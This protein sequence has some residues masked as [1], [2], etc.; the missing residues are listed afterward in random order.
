MGT[1]ITTGRKVKAHFRLVSAGFGNAMREYFSIRTRAAMRIIGMFMEV[2][3]WGVLGML[4]SGNV[5]LEE[6]IRS[7]YMTPDMVSFMLSGLIINRMVDMAQIFNP[8]FFR[9]GYKTYHNRPF[10][11]WV[12][13]LAK[14]LDSMFFWRFMGLIMYILVAA[15][16]FRVNLNYTSVGFWFVILL[17]ALFRLGLN[18]FTA[19]WTVLTKGEQDPI[20]WFYN[21]T[22]RLFTG[23]LIP[24]TYIK[25]IPL[26]GPY[27]HYVSLVHPKTYVQTEGRRAAIGGAGLG[28]VAPNL[29]VPL[30]AAIFFLV[31]GYITLRVAIKRAKR[32]GIMKWG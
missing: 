30:I 2:A 7:F 27:L 6:S 20:N 21:T 15:F 25:T 26:V 19:G 32:E 12:V 18:L 3:V 4:M 23:E 11:I 1:E 22:S 10:N 28:E 13:A 9:M 31:L 5:A 24:I 29:I 17:G 14:N 16:V 8:W